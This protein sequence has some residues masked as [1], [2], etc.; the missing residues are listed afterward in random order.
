MEVESQMTSSLERMVKSVAKVREPRKR[1]RLQGGKR[2]LGVPY[3]FI[4]HIHKNLEI[5]F[6]RN[7][8]RVYSSNNLQ[9]GKRSP[10]NG[11]DRSG[12]IKAKI[13]RSY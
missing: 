12:F 8:K 9:M 6:Q 4:F 7:S 3:C 11:G 13:I 2:R 10:Q 5:P 1:P